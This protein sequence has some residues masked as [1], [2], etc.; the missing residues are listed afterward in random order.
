MRGGAQMEMIVTA[1]ERARIG[2]KTGLFE[3][4]LY[5]VMDSSVALT[6]VEEVT[7]GRYYMEDNVIYTLSV[8]V[9]SKTATY[10]VYS[11]PFLT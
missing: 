1:A 10:F 9:K 11:S 6:P 3:I 7:G 5:G 2:A 8:P 4:C